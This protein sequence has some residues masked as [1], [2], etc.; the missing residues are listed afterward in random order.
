LCYLFKK[1]SNNILLELPLIEKKNIINI[2]STDIILCL[3]H[4]FS[5]IV[6][7]I[8]NLFTDNDLKKQEL[9]IKNLIG[10]S[11]LKKLKF[12]FVN[13]NEEKKGENGKKKISMITGQ[14]VSTFFKNHKKI[15]ENFNLN[16]NIG[17][18]LK[19]ILIF[20]KIMNQNVKFY[21]NEINL[22]LIQKLLFLIN[23]I[24]VLNFNGKY[25]KY[26][27]FLYCH[28]ITMIK[29]LKDENLTMMEI[30][31]SAIELYTTTN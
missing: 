29:K 18:L 22:Q 4:G 13:K 24:L 11:S 28:V 31:N 16:E 12:N 10:F 30:N 27:H 1:L 6:E 25:S 2:L 14:G 19:L 21:K 5:R 26:F 15:F 20:Y 8:I 7:N 17:L 23:L 9:I 3:L